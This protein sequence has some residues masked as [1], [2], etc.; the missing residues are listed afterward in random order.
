M[1]FAQDILQIQKKMPTKNYMTNT[2]LIFLKL[3]LILKA[4][5]EIK[6]PQ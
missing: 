1:F 6:I 4:F 3:P 2:V 5:L